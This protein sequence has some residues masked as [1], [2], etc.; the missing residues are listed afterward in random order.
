DA[1]YRIPRW[2]RHRDRLVTEEDFREIV[3]STPGVDLG[4]V[5]VLPLY[6]PSRRGDAQ[7]AVTILVIPLFD[8]QHPDNPEPDRLFLEAVCRHLEPRRL[9][10]TELYLSGPEY[11]DVIVS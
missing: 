1:E 7:G 4:R 10:T 9:I 11:Q 2:L 8:A 5:E 6:H 3:W